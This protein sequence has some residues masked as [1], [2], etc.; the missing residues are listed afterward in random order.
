M[1]IGRMPICEHQTYAHSCPKCA[2]ER[3]D[4]EDRQNEYFNV[5]VIEEEVEEV[6]QEVWDSIMSGVT[7]EELKDEAELDL[8]FEF[9]W[10]ED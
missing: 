1:P 6:S 7:S 10:E 5:D 8:N 2:E 4:Y 9:E 3:V